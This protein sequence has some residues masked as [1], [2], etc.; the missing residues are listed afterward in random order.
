MRATRDDSGWNT[1]DPIPTHPTASR[2][3][4]KLGARASSTS[5][6]SVALIP[7]GSEYG[8]GRRSVYSPT[9]GCNKDAVSCEVSA[10]SP[11]CPKSSLYVSFKMGYTAGITDCN[12]SFRK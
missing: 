12:I 4:P 3:A 9:A 5:P 10:I 7:T 6:T 2:I 1:A 11:I 8:V